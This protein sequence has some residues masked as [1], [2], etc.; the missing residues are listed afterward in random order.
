MAIDDGDELITAAMTDGSCDLLLGKK[1]GKTIR[2]HEQNIR[3]MGRAA[4]GVRGTMLEKGDEVVSMAVIVGEGGT[5]LSLTA[6]G[7]G[8]RTKIH[9]YRVTRRG[10][11]GVISIKTTKRNGHVVAVKVVNENDEVMIMTTN[12]VMIRLPVSGISVIGRNTQ[13]V[14]VINLA[15]GDLVTD[16]ACVVSEEG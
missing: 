5:I 6:N 2:F 11:K 13:G 4:R 16:V 14:R 1:H 15:A 12:G 9:D 7:Y 10:G 8:K 3:E